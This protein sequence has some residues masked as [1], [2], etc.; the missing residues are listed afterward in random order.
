MSTLQESE[1]STTYIVSTLR[2]RKRVNITTK[3]QKFNEEEN[4][5]NIFK[6]EALKNRVKEI[7]SLAKEHHQQVTQ[8]L[9]KKN[10]VERTERFFSSSSSLV[11][12]LT[13]NQ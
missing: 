1:Y 6:L 13:I 5:E 2:T 9:Q 8:D 4:K 12:Y 3:F 11:S 7:D 10:F